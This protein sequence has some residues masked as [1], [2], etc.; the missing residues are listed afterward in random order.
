MTNTT[1]HERYLSRRAQ[2]DR[3]G[4]SVRTIERWGED[5][6]LALPPELDINGRKLRPLSA[7]E[8]WERKRVVRSNK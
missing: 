4:K 8:Q 7:L 1:A 3:Y 5:P 2:A 6:D